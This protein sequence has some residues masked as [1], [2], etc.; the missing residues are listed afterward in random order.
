MT[1]VGAFLAGLALAA[2]AAGG[3]WWYFVAPK[4]RDVEERVQAAER[5]ALRA[6]RDA[7]DRAGEADSER[8]RRLELEEQVVELKRTLSASPPSRPAA[9]MNGSHTPKPTSGDLTPEMWDN[10][11]V[12]NEI[13]SL[14]TAPRPFSVAPRFALVVRALKAHPDDSITLLGNVLRS[15]L[16]NDTKS[17][18]ATL[19][20]A[21]GDPRGA[22]PLLDT[23]TSAT[24]PDLRQ[25]M[26]QGRGNLP[27]AEA[28]PIFV[29]V[30]NDPSADAKSRLLAIHGLARRRHPIA[31]AVAEG[32]APGSSPPLRLQAL[33][34]LHAQALAGEW[35]DT[36]LVKSFGKALLS[37]DGDPQRKLALVALEGFWSADSLADLDAF[38]NSAVSTELAQRARKTSD[39]I[40]AGSPRPSGA[41]VPPQRPGVPA[42]TAPSEEPPP[43]AV[44]QE[45]PK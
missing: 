37:A 42:E 33:Q 24:D 8:R 36:D 3:A 14:A 16:D 40:R 43:A 23:W 18:C 19:L 41:G 25:A 26:L 6:K 21:L 12:R 13:V 7:S 31:V 17:L 9:P 4:A 5:A 34:T 15:Q 27:G 10:T 2:A 35:K 32:G 38:A 39:A 30:W 44:P 45:P 29:G 11:R 28:T 22:K 1:K 20:G